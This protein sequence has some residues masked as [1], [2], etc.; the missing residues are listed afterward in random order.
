MGTFEQLPCP[1][2]CKI[3]APDWCLMRLRDA[4]QAGAAL[5]T[6]DRAPSWVQANIRSIPD[7]IEA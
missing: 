7:R 4:R 1:L 2:V 5:G 3:D 6:A